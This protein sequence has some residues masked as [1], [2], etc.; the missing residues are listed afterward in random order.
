M[1]SLLEINSLLRLKELNCSADVNIQ[2][3]DI[4]GLEFLN[5]SS[6][7]N[8]IFDRFELTGIALTGIALTTCVLAWCANLKSKI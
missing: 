5:C 2:T 8:K 3:A 6:G 4:E 1:S 7:I